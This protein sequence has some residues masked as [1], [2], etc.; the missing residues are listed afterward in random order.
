MYILDAMCA[1]GIETG[2]LIK[3]GN[4]A[5]KELSRI[6]YKIFTSSLVELPKGRKPLKWAD[7]TAKILSKI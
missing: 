4:G 7:V 5:A 2:Y 3:Q 6:L 1:S